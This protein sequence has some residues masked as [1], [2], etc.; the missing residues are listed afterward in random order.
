VS[1]NFELL[2][3]TALDA[4]RGQHFERAVELY[5]AALQLNPA[6]AEA[7]Y[8]RGNALRSLGRMDAAIVSYRLAIDRKPDHA[9]AYCNLGVAQQAL[10]MTSDALLS[11]D[12]AIALDPA[13]P[14]SHYNRALLMQ[15]LLRWDQALRSYD[16]AIELN[17]R[18]ADAQYNRAVTQLFCGD[19]KHGWRNYEWRWKNAQRLG[20][21]AERGFSE[22]L[23]LGETDISGKRL[24]VH[25]EGG[26]GD[27]LQF[28]RYASLLAARGAVVY[29]EVQ[30][31][32]RE[33]LAD[34]DGVSRLLVKG[35]AVPPFDLHCP[36]MSLP[37]AM[38]TTLDTIPFAAKY[39]HADFALVARW[40]ALLKE[41]DRPRVGIVWSGNP[42]NAIDRRRSISLS[43]L[44][45]HLP[46]Q[47]EYFCLQTDVR[48][49]DADVLAAQS[50]IHRFD[51]GAMDFAATAALCECMDIV[52]SVDTSIAHLSAALGRPTWLLL[53]LIPDWRWLRDR[54]DTPWYSSAT[55]FRQTSAGNWDEVL[56]RVAAELRRMHIC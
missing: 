44:Q 35:E 28:C 50:Q 38:Q 47:C 39:L 56:T 51:A 52:I 21:G 54:P 12:R 6:H 53:P 15:D 55:L 17:P 37:L 32:L 42:S 46:A 25:S 13:D 8:K 22:P 19:F 16:R 40:R 49:A 29:L 1:S 14:I 20:F 23:W 3:T 33:L 2:Y 45:Q 18:F 30:A 48:K 41:T 31:P 27:T 5:D 4:A 43:E 34:L 10:G 26:L 7:L 24:L 9:H 36:L 11:Y